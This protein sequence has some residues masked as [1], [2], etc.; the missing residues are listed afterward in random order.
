MKQYLCVR[1]Y[2]KSN[3]IYKY[4]LIDI[5]GKVSSYT[6]DEVSR[7]VTFGDIEILNLRLNKNG[8]IVEKYYKIK[9]DADFI[10]SCKKLEN[11]VKYTRLLAELSGFNV[12]VFSYG[13]H[14]NLLFM[15]CS[16][17]NRLGLRMQ[18]E[19]IWFPEGLRVECY[20]LGRLNDIDI[21]MHGF[22]IRFG[23][24]CFN[25]KLLIHNMW[26]IVSLAYDI[27][28]VMYNLN[29]VNSPEELL[30]TA[31]AVS[32]FTKGYMTFEALGRIIQFYSDTFNID[33]STLIQSKLTKVKHNKEI[34]HDA[35]RV[36]CMTTQKLTK[37]DYLK[38]TNAVLLYF[39]LTGSIPSDFESLL[40]F[41]KNYPDIDK[42]IV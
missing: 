41:I 33:P 18:I 12:N 19:A 25:T 34:V 17:N 24:D 13:K 1:K 16:C 20:I 11:M 30:N 9:D 2:K 15:Q 23:G 8:K 40:D 38:L 21:R 26:D 36:I 37:G 10:S 31:L 42:F 4:D 22:N 14:P 28:N 29:N 6:V 3:R 39:A 5:N 27:R 35:R 32:W 7:L